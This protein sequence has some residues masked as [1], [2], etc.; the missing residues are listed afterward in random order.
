MKS[1]LCVSLVLGLIA[2]ATALKCN[3]CGFHFGVCFGP[4]SPIDCTGNC[5]YTKA[6]LGSQTLFYSQ[7]CSPN[8]EALKNK[9]DSTFSFEYVT[10]CCNTDQCNS[11]T[12][13]K[14]SLSLGLGMALMWLLNA[15]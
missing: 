10:T 2:V 9:T 7:G 14:I 1:F 5:T 15:L 11:G 3:N 13:V 12:S 6:V 4:S 8:C